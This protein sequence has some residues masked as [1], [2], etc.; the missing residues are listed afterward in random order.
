MAETRN[1]LATLYY[2][3]GRYEEARPLYERALAVEQK[4]L[5]AA[6]PSLATTLSNL[7]ELHRAEGQLDEAI[8]LHRRAL[9]V[10]EKALGPNHP[11]TA[12]SL[13]NLAVRLLRQG[14]LRR[15]R[16]TVPA[17][18]RDQGSGARHGASRSSR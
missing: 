12:Q 9:D 10:R 13:N 15:G 2:A 18:H 11:E 17:Q 3:Q 7:A 14:R 4:K 5:G 1:N 16:A 8:K 6:H